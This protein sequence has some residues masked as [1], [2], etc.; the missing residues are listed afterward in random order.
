MA[1]ADRLAPAALLLALGTH[2]TAGEVSVRIEQH[3]EV[4]IVAADFVANAAPP[5]AWRV[6]TDYD[7]LA[8]FVPGMR[9]SRIVSTPGEPVVLEQKGTS[10]FLFFR[11]PVEVLAR[12]D[13]VPMQS[14][15]FQSIGGNLRN[16]RGE[17]VLAG[18][19]HATRVDYRAEI[20]PEFS[21]PPLLGPALMGQNVRGMVE[22][23]AR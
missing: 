15:K 12:I 13:E 19:D 4:Y 17:W 23:V 2:A 22:A 7:G 5:V 20:T 11:V 6:L 18:H 9:S 10:G 21:L 8:G 1:F 14:V 3:G 16:K